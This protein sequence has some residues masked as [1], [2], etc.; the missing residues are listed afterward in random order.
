MVSLVLTSIPN[1]LCC[2]LEKLGVEY[3]NI[4]VFHTNLEVGIVVSP[5]SKI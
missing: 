2:N 3:Y 1:P 5:Q 4:S